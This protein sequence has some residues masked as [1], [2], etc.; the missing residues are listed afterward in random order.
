MNPVPVLTYHSLDDSGNRYFLPLYPALAVFA[1][2]LLFDVWN[3]AGEAALAS[4]IAGGLRGL[5]TRLR[6]S[7]AVWTAA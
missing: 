2:M 6:P 3:W 5:A 1:A 4:R 7:G